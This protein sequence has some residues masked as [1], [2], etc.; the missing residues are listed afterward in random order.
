[1]YYSYCENCKT[2]ECTYKCTE[3]LMDMLQEKNYKFAGCPDKE[4]AKEAQ[5]VLFS[6]NPRRTPY[7]LEDG[8]HCTADIRMM[9]DQNDELYFEIK[10]IPFAFESH[11]EIGAC[12][13]YE[14]IMFLIA[15]IFDIY[16]EYAD[17]IRNNYTI[18]IERGYISEF[19]PD[20]F[21]EQYHFC[22]ET[23]KPDIIDFVDKFVEYVEDNAGE[24]THFIYKCRDDI[25]ISFVP[26]IP[27][28]ERNVNVNIDTEK[29]DA[30]GKAEL[31]NIEL[32]NLIINT[33]GFYFEIPPNKTGT[34]NLEK[35]VKLAIDAND[36]YMQLI[37]NF[38]KAKNSFYGLDKG[39][40][41]VHEI[42][43]KQNNDTLYCDEK[44]ELTRI[45]ETLFLNIEEMLKN[46]I[47]FIKQY[48]EYFDK[49]YLFVTIGEKNYY[50]ELF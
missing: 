38:E 9:N 19:D 17:T 6:L 21:H 45:G 1:M 48:A 46:K 7:I 8:A 4:P 3:I 29:T 30:V 40:Y 37:K 36:L 49:S 22:P 5:E 32:C 28:N 16:N 10:R 24:W 20:T 26:G 31:N 43:F 11:N 12:K 2:K 50:C 35:Y 18:R 42:F 14:R 27:F 25:V 41:V 33:A 15:E 13:A 39:R 34:V 44:D 23:L 47:N